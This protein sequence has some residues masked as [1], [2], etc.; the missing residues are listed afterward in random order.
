MV[1]GGKL[2]HD[3]AWAGAYVERISRMALR[4]KNH[5]SIIMWS[6]GNEA[7]SGPNHAAMAAWIKDYDMTRPLHYEP[8]M[9][10][11]R[12]KVILNPGDTR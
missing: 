5:P 6:L 11:R 1:L 7:G 12:K 9:A 3:A 10:V 2:S 4:D 8:A